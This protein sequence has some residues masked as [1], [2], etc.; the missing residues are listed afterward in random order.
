[1]VNKIAVLVILCVLVTLYLVTNRQE[2]LKEENKVAVS[3]SVNSI[4]NNGI[5]IKNTI[6]A[7]AEEKQLY[8]YYSHAFCGVDKNIFFQRYGKLDHLNLTEEVLDGLEKTINDCEQWFI[9][10][11]SMDEESRNSLVQTLEERK[12]LITA[13][14][15]LRSFD[16]KTHAM[17]IT[18]VQS[19]NPEISSFALTYLLNFDQ[20]FL[21]KIAGQMNVQNV[22]FLMNSQYPSDIYRCLKGDDCSA[23]SQVMTDICIMDQTT[24]GLSYLDMIR[25]DITPNQ[26]DD[27]MRALQ[28]VDYLINSDWFEQREFLNPNDP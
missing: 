2:K 8:N 24:C 7:N 27:I 20:E 16:P 11:E 14:V 12:E 18:E 10:L 13:F 6:K 15:N 19:D 22:N 26:Y 3:E 5:E 21:Q 4:P 23:T 17:A 9:D 28:I 25:N 1:V